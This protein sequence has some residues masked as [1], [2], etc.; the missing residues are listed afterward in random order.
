M[1]RK[2]VRAKAEQ[3]FE[4]SKKLSAAVKEFE[5][6][7]LMFQKQNFDRAKEIFERLAASGPVEVG[8]RA[9]SYLK[10]CEQ[11][12]AAGTPASRSARDY[13]DLGVAQL[14]ARELDAAF[15]S[16]TRADKAAPN[17]EHVR[18]AL[19]AVCALRG[20]ADT[21]LEHLAGAIELR[22][23]NRSMAAQDQD[24]YPLSSDSRFRRLIRSG[25]S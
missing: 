16:L 18:Y 25:G 23:A 8:S 4:F 12:L 24:F 3:Q 2:N 22:P 1:K 7:V 6:A 20:N 15:E 19:A 21:A 14:N 5:S 10:I 17:Q 9:T 13:Y 11:K